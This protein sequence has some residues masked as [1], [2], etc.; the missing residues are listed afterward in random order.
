MGL[1]EPDIFKG[2]IVFFFYRLGRLS[3]DSLVLFFT[4]INFND[5]LPR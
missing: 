4:V 1:E 2:D 5:S 3:Y